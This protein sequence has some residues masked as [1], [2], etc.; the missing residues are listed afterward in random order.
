[1]CLLDSLS[2]HYANQTRIG[3]QN[4]PTSP[5]PKYTLVNPTSTLIPKIFEKQSA[6]Q[7]IT[8]TAAAEVAKTVHLTAEAVNTTAEAL[9]WV[10]TIFGFSSGYPEEDSMMGPSGL[11]RTSIG[12]V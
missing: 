2:Q 5:L 9:R 11:L 1:M 3:Y 7:G 12:T 8:V 10:R 4:S 6:T